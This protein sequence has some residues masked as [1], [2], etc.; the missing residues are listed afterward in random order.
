[1]LE[2][3]SGKSGQ[4]YSLPAV[5]MKVLELTRN[6][7]VDIPALK[8]CIENDPALTG[9]ILRV[10]NSSL[11]GLSREVSDLNQALALL[12][13]KPL[14]MLVLGFSLPPGLFTGVSGESLAR[15]WRHALTKAVAA[16]ELCETFYQSAGDEAFIAGL[17]QNIGELLLMQELGAPYTSFLDK[18]HVGGN[19]LSTLEIETLG[20]EHEVLSARLLGSWGLP[21]VIVQTVATTNPSRRG[22]ELS[23]EVRELSE[24]VYLGELV[25]RLLVDRRPEAL[26]KLLVAGQYFHEI[27]KAQLEPMVA[28]LEDKVQQLADVLSLQLPQGADYRDILAEAHAQLV[29]VADE[30]AEDM[31]RR[32]QEQLVNTNV[33]EEVQLLT[34]AVAEASSYPAASPSDVNKQSSDSHSVSQ[35]S[36]ASS[37]Q[38][39][40]PTITAAS[41]APA[42]DSSVL[43]QL[44]SSVI[45]C[46]QAR[47]PI[48]LLLPGLCDADGLRGRLGGEA[49]DSLQGALERVCRGVIQPSGVCISRGHAGFALVLPDCER[50]EAVEIGNQITERFRVSSQLVIGG[51][52]SLVVDVGIGAATVSLPPKNFPAKDLL[53]AADRCLYGSQ[54]SGGGVVKSIEIY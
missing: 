32:Q 33:A 47:C 4:L 5:A 39:V 26:R 35:Q 37:A 40:A 38:T 24:V 1:M 3:L 27:T 31:L 7:Q 25:A 14:K 45:A 20:F 8:Q 22:E 17:L 15:Y 10:V 18:V 23:D 54:T 51:D 34:A 41:T 29:S 13:T 30:A 12:G 46:R 42:D 52:E 50:R 48:S 21:E 44:A 19:D 49:V 9:K 36:A 16:R 2:R 11:F 43:N 6:P 28:D 53:T